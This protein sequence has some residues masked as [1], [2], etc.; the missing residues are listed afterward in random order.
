MRW[1]DDV[2]LNER[3][4]T[5]D[6]DAKALRL[7]DRVLR[8]DEFIA[9]PAEVLSLASVVSRNGRYQAGRELTAIAARLR[10]AKFF[11]EAM[12]PK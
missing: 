2:F 9:D 12:R 3:E 7:A 10:A 1:N 11:A 8:G 4:S 6:A 5:A